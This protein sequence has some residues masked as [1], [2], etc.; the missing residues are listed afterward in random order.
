VTWEAMRLHAPV[1]EGGGL[2]HQELLR[3]AAAGWV[4]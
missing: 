4:C 1:V 3:M 2:L